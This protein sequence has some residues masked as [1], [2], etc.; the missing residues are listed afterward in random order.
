MRHTGLPPPVVAAIE[1]LP[2]DAHPMGVLITGN[3]NMRTCLQST[4]GKYIPSGN[5]E[6]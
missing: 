2:C 3:C 1:A 5:W 6:I 4:T